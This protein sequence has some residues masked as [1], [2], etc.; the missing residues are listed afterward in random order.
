LPEA[1]LYIL[2]VLFIAVTLFFPGG[3]SSLLL[4]KKAAA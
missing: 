4:R 2:G 1:W 3:L